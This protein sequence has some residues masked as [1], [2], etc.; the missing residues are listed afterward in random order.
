MWI[1]FLKIHKI[2]LTKYKDFINKFSFV[3]IKIGGILKT[4]L[5]KIYKKNE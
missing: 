2:P 4:K 1:L 3:K 5:I